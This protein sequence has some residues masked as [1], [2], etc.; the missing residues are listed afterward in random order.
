MLGSSFLRRVWAGFLD[1]FAYERSG[2]PVGVQ[3]L[4]HALTFAAA[5]VATIYVAPSINTSFEK[6]KRRSEFYIKAIEALNDDTKEV[7]GG[8]VLYGSDLDADG[9]KEMYADLKK[10]LAKLQW[11]SVEFALVF[12]DKR[13]DDKIKRYQSALKKVDG[14]LSKNG[15]AGD[16]SAYRPAVEEF[17]MASAR[18]VEFLAHEADVTI[19]KR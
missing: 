10:G 5:V 17:G 12:D 8:L 16:A 19:S 14:V 2:M 18:M 1:S 4:I 11:R 3:I 6:E 13:A 15:I 7:L 9:R